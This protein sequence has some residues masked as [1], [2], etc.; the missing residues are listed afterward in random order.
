[1]FTLLNLVRFGQNESSRLTKL[2]S[3]LNL[4]PRPLARR[5]RGLCFAFRGHG[6][7]REV[8]LHFITPG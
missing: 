1:M 5:L 7:Q 8:N 2:L 4:S 3:S 6:G